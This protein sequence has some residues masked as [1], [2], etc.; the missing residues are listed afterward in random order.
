MRARLTRELR[1]QSAHAAVAAIVVIMAAL[2]GFVG[3]VFAAFTVGLVREVTEEGTPVTGA[4]LVRALGS[5][6]DLLGWS[7]GGVIAAIGLRWI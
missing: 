2:F 4:K 6:R 3:A 1:D 5:W 7:A